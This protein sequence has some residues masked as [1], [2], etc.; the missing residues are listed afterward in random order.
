MSIDERLRDADV[1]W[2]G[3]R[4]EGALLSI[5]VA[6]TGA[7]RVS[8]PDAKGDGDAFRRF[9]AD[10]HTWTTKIEHRGKLVDF[11]QLMWKWLRC[12]L[13]HTGSLP[14]DVQFF[15]EDDDPDDLRIQA[16]GAPGYC[17]RLSDGWYWW[18]RRLV[19]DWRDECSTV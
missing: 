13:A 14:V 9:L 3:G 7:A 6:I 12:E 17:V 2:T 19:E 4:R 10:R 8:Y 1:L 15:P 18:L 16:G 11:D 5:L